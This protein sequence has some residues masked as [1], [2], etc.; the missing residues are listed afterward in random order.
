MR[1]WIKM[2]GEITPYLCDRHPA[3]GVLQKLARHLVG[4]NSA[5]RPRLGELLICA[6]H[7]GLNDKA[8]H[9]NRE[10]REQHYAVPSVKV[11]PV[12]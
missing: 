12:S 11:K 3:V 5:G 7:P 2:I 1:F 10:K 4:G 8:K 9:Q 6:L